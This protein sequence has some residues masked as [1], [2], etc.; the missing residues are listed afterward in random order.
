MAQTPEQWFKNMPTITKT[1]FV[2]AVGTTILV[3]LNIVD[4]EYLYLDFDLVFKKFQFWRLV[5]CFLFFGKFS[6]P[7]IFQI[8]ILVHYFQML[9]QGYFIG[10]RGLAEMSF[11][12][13]FVGF[14]MLVFS[15]FWGNLYFMGPALVFSVLYIWSRKDPYRPVSF[16]G[17]AF[18]AWQ[19]PFAMMIFHILLGASPLLDGVG[20]V[21]GHV[22]HFLMDIVPA[23]YGVQVL[24][25]PQLFYNLFEGGNAYAANSNWQRTTGYRMN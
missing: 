8:F 23:N 14:L 10:N 25:T 9:E 20:I 5:T 19:F 21:L 13:T 11:M 24:K 16:W 4:P 12:L 3:Q 18:S 15:Y 2:A 17:F 1:Y 6:L 22:Y 7:F